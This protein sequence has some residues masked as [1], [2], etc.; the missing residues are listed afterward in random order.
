MTVLERFRAEVPRPGVD[1]LRAEEARL[2]AA[3]AGADAG[4]ESAPVRRVRPARRGRLTIGV[5]GGL[6]AAAAAG[7]VVVTARGPERDAVTH[8]MPVAASRVLTR[9]ADA[10]TGFPELDP[11]AG[12]FLVFE[13][14]TMDPVE[15]NSA[16][17]H[18]R[19]LARSVRKVWLPVE[20]DSTRGVVEVR[21][22][23]PRPYPGWPIPAS[24]GRAGPGGG[25]ERLA[26]FDDRA[27]FL[28]NDF[29]YVSRLP[30]EP[31]KMYEHLY[32]R[33]GTGAQADVEAW[34][35][36][37]GLLTEAYLPSAQRVALY[38]AAAA[39]PGVTTVDE[40]VDAAGRAGIAAAK[41]VGGV[42]RE[43]IFDRRTYRYLG[44]REVV[45]DAAL[46][47][48]PV[49][50]VLTSTAQLKVSVADRAPRVGS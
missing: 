12:Q 15:S 33:L 38:R 42:R 11:K 41:I 19:Y 5:A 46:A 18:A 35:R 23:A 36:V 29:A 25:P 50:S 27:E 28:R 31:R 30:T 26:D 32:T 39:I 13:S 2:M 24:A 44:Q 16:Q 37:G 48:A 8:V 17:G 9:A 21:M 3:I 1:E 6:A 49:G 45:T 7:V 20:G 10:S 14:Q 43:Y 47:G 22:L 40:A 34:M 4:V